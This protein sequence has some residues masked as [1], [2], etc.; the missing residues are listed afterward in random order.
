MRWL[1]KDLTAGK[2]YTIYDPEAS[3]PIENEALRRRF[4]WKRDQDLA[5]IHERIEHVSVER[6]YRIIGEL[7]QCALDIEEYYVP[8]I[9]GLIRHWRNLVLS[10]DFGFL[11][12]MGLAAGSAFMLLPALQG[13]L[14][15]ALDWLNVE[16]I[17]AVAAGAAAA[18][19]ALYIHFS[20]RGWAAKRVNKRIIQENN[21]AE[22]TNLS[23][24]FKRNTHWWR[25]VFDADPAGWSKRSAKVIKNVLGAADSMVQVLNDRFTDPSGKRPVVEEPVLEPEPQVVQGEIVP[26]TETG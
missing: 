25:S 3:V 17:R 24:A 21:E 18:I 1:K 26:R 15:N 4:E 2:F 9:R 22:A 11:L 16:P 23:R 8:K 14:S 7:E 12:M 6:A 20:V 19:V 10:A 5:E 13:S